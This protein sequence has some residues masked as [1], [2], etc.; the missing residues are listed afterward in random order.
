[1]AIYSYNVT[2]SDVTDRLPI[3][4]QAIT[5][6]SE[7]LST[8]DIDEYIDDAAS[9]FSGVL[10][11]SGIQGSDLSDEAERQIQIG[12]EHY[13]VAESLKQIGHTGSDYEEARDAY[14]DALK[15]FRDQPQTLDKNHDR[16]R[17]NVDTTRDASEFEEV[18][19]RF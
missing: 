2:S 7:P 18:D 5:S 4:T 6:S 9:E 16:V 14:R 1:M 19:Y 15:R 13:A 11:K 8:S 17:S 12:I 10:E 3:D